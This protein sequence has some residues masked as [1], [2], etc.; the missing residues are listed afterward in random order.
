M[1]DYLYYNLYSTCS[2]LNPTDPDQPCI[3]EEIRDQSILKDPSQ[4]KFSIIRFS[5]N[6]NNLPAFIPKIQTGQT[7]I[8][9]TTYGFVFSYLSGRYVSDPIFLNYQCRNKYSYLSSNIQTPITSSRQTSQYYFTY[10]IQDFVDMM[11]IAFIQGTNNINSKA[12]IT[13]NPPI[14]IFNKLQNTFSIYYDS[15]YFGAFDKMVVKFNDDLYNLF[16]NFNSYYAS[17]GGYNYEMIVSNKMT[18]TITINNINYFIETQ[19]YPNMQNFSPVSTIVFLSNMGVKQELISNVNILNINNNSN[20]ANNNI[21]PI[22]TDL[23]LGLDNP[24]DVNNFIQYIPSGQFRESSIIT[25]ELK[26]ISFN[27]Y[28][29]DKFGNTFPILLSDGDACTL[30]IKFQKL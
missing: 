21:Q 8:N 14:M 18:N 3:F 13:M 2:K 22:I 29:R 9:L 25:E 20:G 19:S 24:M 16:R 4:Y 15:N 11:N 6:S 1:T 23:I 7:N 12:S 28:W 10:D 26:Y 27:V 17:F 5:L 30:K